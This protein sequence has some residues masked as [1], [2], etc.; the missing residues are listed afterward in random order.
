M[1]KEQNLNN[2]FHSITTKP[3]I[4]SRI[5]ISSFSGPINASLPLKLTVAEPDLE[6]LRVLAINELKIR[7]IN[8]DVLIICLL[9]NFI[10]DFLRNIL[11]IFI[12]AFLFCN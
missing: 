5:V 8:K 11:D 10:N 12:G 3:L 7:T 2:S 9:Y 6:T 4:F 1:K